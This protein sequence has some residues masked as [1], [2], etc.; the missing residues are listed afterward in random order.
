MTYQSDLS[1]NNSIQY[2]NITGDEV[3]K[4][5]KHI[6]AINKKKESIFSDESACLISQD[7]GTQQIENNHC[8]L[9]DIFTASMVKTDEPILDFDIVKSISETLLRNKIISDDDIM[10]DSPK[11]KMFNQK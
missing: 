3:Q 5:L 1:K 10:S 8:K 11:K 6:E 4:L 7:E 9:L 2:N